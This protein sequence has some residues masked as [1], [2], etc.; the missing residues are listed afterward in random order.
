MEGWRRGPRYGEWMWVGRVVLVE[1]RV[2]T[3]AE[4]KQAVLVVF[5][6]QGA[7][8]LL[9]VSWWT[10]AGPVHLCTQQE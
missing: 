9:S 8:M 5:Y 3:G 1:G 2:M 10:H 4:P 7:E 6:Q